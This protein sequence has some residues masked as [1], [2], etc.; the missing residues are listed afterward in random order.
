MR[1]LTFLLT[2][3]FLL[4]LFGSA[5]EEKAKPG[6]FVMFVGVDISGSFM[7]GGHFD[8]SLKFLATYLYT[9]MQGMGD[10][11]VPHSLFVGSIGG[12]KVDE[13]KTFYPIQAFQDKNADQIEAQLH[14]IFPRNKKNPFTDYNAF[15]KQVATFVQN[16]K[17]VMRPI[18]IVLISDGI[19]DAPNLDGKYDFR[20]LNIKTLE[21][22]TR[23][24]TVRLLYTNPVVAEKWQTK[25]P[26]Q[27]VKVWAQ[28]ATVMRLWNAGN[29]FDPKLPLNDQ[30]KFFSWLKDNVDFN[31]RVK[32]VD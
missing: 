22:L 3:I 14:Q 6:R 9:H 29:I 2:H 27:R 11:D 30:G 31:V 1:L 25:I 10:L 7:N 20:N 26:R 23:N 32:R 8:N 21:N 17:L 28:D 5:N 16:K 4:P 13:A 15:F 18:S 19:P 12:S 24:I